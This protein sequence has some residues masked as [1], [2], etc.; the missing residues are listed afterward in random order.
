MKRWLRPLAPRGIR[1][2]RIWAG[3]IRGRRIVTSWHD[4]PA[5]IL[6]RTELRLLEWLEAQAAPGETW[7]DVG[8]HYGYTAIAMAERVGSKGRVFAFEPS[9]TTVGYLNR[10][11]ALNGYEQ[12]RVVPFGLGR[13][14]ELTPIEVAVSRGM[15]N[16]ALGGEGTELIYS[17]ALEAVWPALAGADRRVHGVKVDVQG[18]EQGVLEGMRGILAEQRPKLALELH[19]GVDRSAILALLAGC[20]Y[21]PGEPIE[22]LGDEPPAAYHDDRSY[23]FRPR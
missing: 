15:A 14:P 12:V 8:A 6:G 17:V 7:L 1:P 23:A 20:G 2:H 13:E 4:Y 22:P 19:P 10:T 21:G 16:H 11:R 5:A 18:A 3:P 9:L